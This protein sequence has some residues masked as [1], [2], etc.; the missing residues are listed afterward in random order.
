M[1]YQA[2][3]HFIRINRII[4]YLNA[5]FLSLRISLKIV[6]IFLHF[7]QVKKALVEKRERRVMLVQLV[8][9]THDDHISR[10]I[11]SP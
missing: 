6:L 8:S 5:H 4:H 10:K 2:R 11:A 3:I 9:T 1:E 7:F